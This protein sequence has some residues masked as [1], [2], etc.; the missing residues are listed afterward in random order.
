[1]DNQLVI[2]SPQNRYYQILSE[3]GKELLSLLTN[4]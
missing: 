4:K 2:L 3:K 1:M